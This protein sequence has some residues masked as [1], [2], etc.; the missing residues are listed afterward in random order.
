MKCTLGGF[1]QTLNA[2][3]K[4]NLEW[5]SGE[6]KNETAFIYENNTNTK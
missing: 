3:G 2:S 5:N 1:K 6:R 4:G